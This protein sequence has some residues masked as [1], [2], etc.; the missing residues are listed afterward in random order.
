MAGKTGEIRTLHADDSKDRGSSSIV[1]ISSHNG[2]QQNVFTINY[3]DIFKFLNVEEI[4]LLKVDCEGSEYEFLLN[5]DLTKVNVICIEIHNWEGKSHL[6]QSLIDHIE[7]THETLSSKDTAH[8]NTPDGIKCHTIKV[9]KR[10][11]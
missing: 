3:E 11:E 6:Q 4:S 2:N 1:P 5:S 7:K 8:A 10:R 9:Y